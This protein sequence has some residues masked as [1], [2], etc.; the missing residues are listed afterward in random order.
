MWVVAAAAVAAA[1]VAAAAA[2]A[3]AA[4]TTLL[5]LL[6][7]LLP[8]SKLVVRSGGW[9]KGVFKQINAGPIQE[10]SWLFWAS[11]G[12]RSHTW[13][14]GVVVGPTGC[15]KDMFWPNPWTVF[16]VLATL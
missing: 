13:R 10:L 12:Q 11:D 9:P 6:L 2:V 3:A 1:P 15:S 5:L 8:L 14:L 4:T 16:V 7:L